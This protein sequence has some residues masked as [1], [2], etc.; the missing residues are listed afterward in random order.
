MSHLHGMFDTGGALV[1]PQEKKIIKFRN[2]K[3]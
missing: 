3:I 2:N 1:L